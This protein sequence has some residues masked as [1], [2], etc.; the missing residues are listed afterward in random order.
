MASG[1]VGTL[2]TRRGQT[3]SSI[4]VRL[5]DSEE[6]LRAT[7]FE[8]AAPAPVETIARVRHL[9]GV[10]LH[11][12]LSDLEVAN[13][14]VREIVGH[15][16][17]FRRDDGWVSL[18]AALL[19]TVERQ[20]G[21]PDALIPIWPDFND[22]GPSGRYL[23]FYLFALGHD[24]LCE[25]LAGEGTPEPI[26]ELTLTVLARHARTYRRKWGSIGVNAGWW[27][28]LVLRGELLQIG[29]LQFHRVNLGVG[30]LSPS[31]WFDEKEA[32]ALGA[33]YRRGDPSLGIHIPDEVDFS[34]A[35][36]DATFDEARHV[37][38][39]VWPTE[40][41]RLATCQSWL[42]DD[43]LAAILGETSNIVGFQRRFEL[44]PIWEN[45]DEDI[46]DFVFRDPRS[47][48]G[49]LALTTTLQRAVV[50]TLE[51]GEHWRARAGWLDFD[52][53]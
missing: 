47:A 50:E 3:F 16:D 44:L 9:N 21:N 43:R 36:L 17:V 26:I 24:G 25:F 33:G 38:G 20:R 35:R 6:S 2:C 45:A 41:R 42:L 30:T 19:N 7:M 51:R 10:A 39:S 37:L 27:M 34:P 22:E 5:S 12:V 48:L 46:V 28:L 13:D 53:T 8:V 49:D 14:D 18:L 1:D 32:T 11:R 29:S 52:G 23:Y 15:W 31:S 40:Q 4:G